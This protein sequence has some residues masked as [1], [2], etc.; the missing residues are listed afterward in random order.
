MHVKVGFYLEQAQPLCVTYHIFIHWAHDVVATLNQRHRRW[1]AT[2]LWARW[3]ALSVAVM[4]ETRLRN[5]VA[6]S[7]DIIVYHHLPLIFSV[8]CTIYNLFVNAHVSRLLWWSP[9]EIPT[10]LCWARR[11]YLLTCKVFLLLIMNETATYCRV[12]T[13]NHNLVC[14][15]L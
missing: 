3:D 13:E 4:F 6:F 15:I 11:Q 2:T 10:L 1:W 14:F 5:Y 9:F 8:M 7:A 12:T